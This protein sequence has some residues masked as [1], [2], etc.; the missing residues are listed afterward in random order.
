[1]GGW[2]YWIQCRRNYTRASCYCN[3]RCI[4]P[5]YS[6]KKNLGIDLPILSPFDSY[7]ST[8]IIKEAML[9]LMSGSL[10]K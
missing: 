5:D 1:M 4:G 3:H 7:I 6:R 8:P 2:F 10:N 9:K